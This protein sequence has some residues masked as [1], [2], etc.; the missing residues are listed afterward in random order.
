MERGEMLERLA[1]A[2]WSW[3]GWA[4]VCLVDLS[5]QGSLGLSGICRVLT[6]TPFTDES[7][8]FVER[9]F[10]HHLVKPS[11]LTKQK[12]NN[13]QEKHNTHNS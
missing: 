6:V 10:I 13:N 9:V 8:G 11:K 7:V 5:A 3:F 2:T 4:V 12:R 1:S